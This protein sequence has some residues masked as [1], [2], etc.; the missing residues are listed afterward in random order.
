[1]RSYDGR[2]TPYAPGLGEQFGGI[3]ACDIITVYC[4]RQY[5]SPVIKAWPIPSKHAL[6]GKEQK[7]CG[8]IH[9]MHLCGLVA[10]NP[11]YVYTVIQ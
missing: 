1:M 7:S 10:S 8:C 9:P 2:V 6:T 11:R 5:G 4:L 3:N